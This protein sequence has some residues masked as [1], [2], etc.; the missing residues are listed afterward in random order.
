MT[1]E[2]RNLYDNADNVRLPGWSFNCCKEMFSLHRVDKDSV[3]D[4]VIENKSERILDQAGFEPAI[5]CLP[6][7][8]STTRPS[9]VRGKVTNWK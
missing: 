6:G 4:L 9:M 5:Y 7:N 8:D 2:S 3:L 1:Y